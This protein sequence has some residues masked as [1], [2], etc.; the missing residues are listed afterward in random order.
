MNHWRNEQ[1]ICVQEWRLPPH[2]QYTLGQSTLRMNVIFIIS[3][4]L[5][6][7]NF[8]STLIFYGLNLCSEHWMLIG[9]WPMGKKVW[10]LD[11]LRF[12]VCDEMKELLNT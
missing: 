4:L 11:P 6:I 5:S 10:F 2:K 1:D 9:L 3:Y 7:S 8:M 12:H